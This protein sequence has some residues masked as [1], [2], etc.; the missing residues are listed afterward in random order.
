LNAGTS[1]PHVVRDYETR[2]MKAHKRAHDAMKMVMTSLLSRG[3]LHDV[4]YMHEETVYVH[5]RD[6]A[7]KRVIDVQDDVRVVFYNP[8]SKRRHEVVDLL[9]TTADVSVNTPKT[10]N[11]DVQVVRLPKNRFMVSFIVDMPAFGIEVYVIKKNDHSKRLSLEATALNGVDLT[12]KNAYLSIHFNGTSGLLRRVSTRDGTTTN[13]TADFMVYKA[14]RSGAY[15]FGPGGPALDFTTGPISCTFV[16]GHL[17]SE[18]T[19]ARPGFRHTYRLYNV[20]GVQGRGIHVT[21]ETDMATVGMKNME[22]VYRINAGVNT[23]G[24]FFTD[25]NGFQLIGRKTLPATPIE[26]NFYPVTTMALMEDARFRL[27]LHVRQPHG[28]GSLKAGQL[29]VM[30]DRHTT[31]DDGRG[32]GQGVYDNVKVVNDFIIQLES[33]EQP[34]DVIDERTTL[35]SLDATLVND[36]LQ[37]R[38]VVYTTEP[39]IRLVNKVHPLKDNTFPCDVSLINFNN[40]YDTDVKYLYSIMTIH[41]R[42]FH[43]GFKVLDLDTENSVCENSNKNTMTMENLF[44]K[45]K[46][47]AEETSLSGYD[48]I[49]QVSARSDIRPDKHELR[50]FK[51]LL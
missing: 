24:T 11:I 32:L 48:V 5:S 19:V 23:S 47:T 15:I 20:T 49:R 10:S 12:M 31:R 51:V 4:K 42:S 22:V 38:M 43:C 28:V 30:L 14:A 9:L 16:L 6:I 35:P 34:F 8:E 13:I 44:P 17:W 21:T 40:V 26:S 36:F 18:V 3:K 27:T 46:M 50:T 2:L 41:R 29:D 37:H 39:G 25:E 7:R 33:K 45:L 1:L